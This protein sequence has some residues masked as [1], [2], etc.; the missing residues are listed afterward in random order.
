[1]EIECFSIFFFFFSSHDSSSVILLITQPDFIFVKSCVYN[2]FYSTLL[3][4]EP[5][6]KHLSLTFEIGSLV[7]QVSR[8][9]FL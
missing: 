8:E 5:L 3:L 4:R 9:A 6:V 7:V 2:H 1:M